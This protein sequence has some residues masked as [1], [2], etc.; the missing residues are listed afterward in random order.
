MRA[1]RI[2]NS[3]WR[4][5]FVNTAQY[6]AF[7]NQVRDEVQDELAGEDLKVRDSA[8]SGWTIVNWTRRAIRMSVASDLLNNT[9]GVC[10]AY[11][12][13]LVFSSY[14]GDSSDLC[15]PY[16]NRIYSIS[17]RFSAH[18]AALDSALWPLGGLFHPNCRHTIEPYFEGVTEHDTTK[19]LNSAIIEQNYKQRQEWLRVNRNFEKYR[20]I[21]LQKKAAGIDYT[22]EYELMRKW[23]D[24]RNAID[25]DFEDVAFGLQV[26]GGRGRLTKPKGYTTAAQQLEETK[27]RLVY[28]TRKEYSA[29]GGTNI[30]R[31]N[32]T[33]A[34]RM[35]ADRKRRENTAKNLKPYEK[36]K[37]NGYVPLSKRPAHT[38]DAIKSYSKTYGVSEEDTNIYW[39]EYANNMKTQRRR[40]TLQGFEEYLNSKI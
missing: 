12:H 14:L 3:R 25:Y 39:Q 32:S 7:V 38:R 26:G 31:S 10:E 40:G 2:T 21:G 36:P 1:E 29:N 23:Q 22:K 17:G 11:G 6:L 33:L 18:H 37:P 15:R 34:K 20:D 8:G 35:E 24:K 9:L 27:P 16:Q 4:Y 5:A 30:Q 19:P 28:K 13:D